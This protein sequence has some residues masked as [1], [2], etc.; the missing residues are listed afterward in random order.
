MPDNAED[1]AGR[2]LSLARWD[3]GQVAAAARRHR[4]ALV[5]HRLSRP[6]RLAL[7]FVHGLGGDP[8]NTWRRFPELVFDAPELANFDVALFRYA[9]GIFTNLVP[10]APKLDIR[11]KSLDLASDMRAL[12]DEDR[13]EGLMVVAHSMGGIMAKFAI[14]QLLE[15]DTI[16][17]RRIL[18][19][20]MCGTPQ[21]GSTRAM[22]PASLLSPDL[23]LL[24]AFSADLSD[25]QVFWNSRI[26]TDSTRASGQRFYLD[27][28]ALIGTRDL[29]VKRGSGV[30]AL[31]YERIQTVNF[32]HTRLVKP[33]DAE[34]PVFRWLLV[35]IEQGRAFRQPRILDRLGDVPP[36]REKLVDGAPDLLIQ[37]TLYLKTYF[38]S[39]YLV[40]GGRRA[41][42]RAGD[43]FVVIHT[44]EMVS[45]SRGRPV[46]VARSHK[47]Y[48]TVTRVEEYVTVCELDT[49]MRGDLA[50]P[51]DAV[52]LP[53]DEVELIPGETWKLYKELQKLEKN[54]NDTKADQSADSL[55]KLLIAI[56]TMLTSYPDSYLAK[57]VLHMKGCTQLAMGRYNEAI[58][59]F[60]TYQARYPQRRDILAKG[61]VDALIEEAQLRRKLAATG[62]QSVEDRVRLAVHLVKNS[63]REAE[64]VSLLTLALD[65]APDVVRKQARGPERNR[66]AALIA[67][68]AAN[69]PV[70]Q[71]LSLVEDAD[72]THFRRDLDQ[73]I[74]TADLGGRE[75]TD[76]LRRLTSLLDN[77]GNE[78]GSIGVAAAV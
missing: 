51:L 14:R 23:R 5:R 30:G 61:G 58:H 12:L 49:V 1:T 15:L 73:F 76:L 3:Q 21:Y 69:V 65:T 6:N 25:L 56:E 59:T 53:G 32:H 34:D 71:V 16:N 7:V 39:T 42:H 22:W 78:P 37:L 50:S 29:L 36:A 55:V 47:N 52:P 70:A 57:P 64:A 9:S 10:G 28:R 31:P 68:H 74:D 26:T 17:A 75:R 27:E 38:E 8:I 41:G 2:V 62:G 43:V 4:L 24:T 54:S 44:G 63:T 19:L 72:A 20:Y 67:V 46:Y 11:E 66:I 33:R 48:L 40:E 18:G 13:Y 60:E 77:A 45:D 35:G